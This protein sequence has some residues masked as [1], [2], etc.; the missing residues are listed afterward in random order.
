[1]SDPTGTRRCHLHAIV[2]IYIYLCIYNYTSLIARFDCAPTIH[3]EGWPEGE[4]WSGSR[5]SNSII[6]KIIF[7]RENGNLRNEPLKMSSFELDARQVVQKKKKN[8]SRGCF[9]NDR[10]MCKEPIV[11]DDLDEL[12]NPFLLPWTKMKTKNSMISVS[13]FISSRSSFEF[14]YVTWIYL[15]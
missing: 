1:M 11:S 15:A 2:H 10:L 8:E 9:K 3:P 14:K 13:M 7:S 5:R 4:A 12:M 6:L